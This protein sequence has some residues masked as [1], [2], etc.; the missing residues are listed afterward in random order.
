MIPHFPPDLILGI[1]A[2]WFKKQLQDLAREYFLDPAGDK[3]MLVEKLLYI[4]ALNEQGDLTELPV[5]AP[6]I[7]P[8]LVGPPKK[9]CCRI[10]GA[11]APADLLEGGKFFERIEW[12]REHYKVVHPGKW[13]RHGN[14]VPAVEERLPRELQTF[15][16]YTVDYRLKEF[17]KAEHGKTLEFIPFDS[18]KG[19]ELLKLM[20]LPYYPLVA[21][22]QTFSKFYG[23]KFPLGQLVMT[24]GVAAKVQ[25]DGN[26][27]AFCLESLKRH[28]HGDWGDLSEEDKKENEYSLDKHLRLFSAYEKK[29]M[30]KIWIITETNRSVTTTLFPEEY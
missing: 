26:F 6:S 16:G 3:E 5:E 23:T 2:K 25:E 10:C 15:K 18:P 21:A 11:C 29:G 14:S 28:A 30:P 20:Q 1:E 24:A 4:G 7:V 22:P 19:Q 8:Y 27:A 12:L 13:G 9:F 17:R